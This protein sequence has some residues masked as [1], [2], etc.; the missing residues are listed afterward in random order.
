M[1]DYTEETKVKGSYGQEVLVNPR[2][3]Q[4]FIPPHSNRLFTEP[5]RGMEDGVGSSSIGG[6][7][8][9]IYVEK[10]GSRSPWSE[11]FGMDSGTSMIPFRIPFEHRSSFFSRWLGYNYVQGTKLKRVL[12][13]VHPY[14]EFMRCRNFTNVQGVGWRGEKPKEPVE[15]G[16]AFDRPRYAEYDQLHGMAV[17]QT[18]PFQ[19]KTDDQVTEEYERFV[20]VR[21]EPGYESLYIIGGSTD[22]SSYLFDNTI[23]TVGGKVS[24]PAGRNLPLAVA[25]IRCTWFDVP[26]DFID[27]T[28]QQGFYQN[29]FDGI[30]KINDASFMGFPAYSLYA[31]PP[32]VTPRPNPLPVDI[33]PDVSYLCNVDFTWHYFYPTPLGTGVTTNLGHNM[34]IYRADRKWYPASIGGTGTTRL[35]ETYDFKKF[36]RKPA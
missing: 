1:P 24:F 13:V 17:F 9:G 11:S 31:D 6:T 10:V 36:F 30:G 7:P 29:L 34:A 19:Y 3:Q 16:P 26:L 5:G 28:G 8:P 15:V 22:S 32:V 33:S 35:F 25:T 23:P 27:N 4:D 12:P 20:W 18:M 14:W 21:P 2:T